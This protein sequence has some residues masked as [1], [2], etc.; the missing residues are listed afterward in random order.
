MSGSLIP[1]H[2]LGIFLLLFVPFNFDMIVFCFRYFIFGI[3]HYYILEAYL[4]PLETQKG[5]GS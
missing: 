1:V 3:F 4:F 2:S 5:S